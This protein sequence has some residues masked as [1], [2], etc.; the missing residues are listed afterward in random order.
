MTLSDAIALLSSLGACVAAIA[1]FLTIREMAT[2]RRL[3]YRPE[4]ILS[5]TTLEA[6]TGAPYARN[7]P[8]RWLSDAKQTDDQRTQ[9]ERMRFGI[10]LV[11]IGPAAA[12]RIEI[13]W[14][15]PIEETTT[16]INRICE[17]ADIPDRIEYRNGNVFCH[18]EL[19][20]IWGSIW[21]NQEHQAIDFV[22]PAAIQGEPTLLHLPDAYISL[23]SA[24]VYFS[25]SSKAQ[26]VP[27]LPLLQCQLSFSDIADE[28]RSLRY[29]ISIEIVA[30][31]PQAESMSFHAI[32]DCMRQL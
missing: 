12:K 20:G 28:P 13:R 9:T 2:Q 31:S 25:M 27:D 3:S 17:L 22:L 8:I 5:G 32:I 26:E 11:N 7:L 6:T 29:T 15:F 10:P 21:R 16:K 19:A 30:C 24:L 14:S 23:T 4:I 18:S 1:A